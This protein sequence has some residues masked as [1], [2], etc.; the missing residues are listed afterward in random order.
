MVGW[1]YGSRIPY[2]SLLYNVYIYIYI[3][4]DTSGYDMWVQN[5][6]LFVQLYQ[7]DLN[8]LRETGL[9]YDVGGIGNIWVWY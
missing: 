2:S 7:Y 1:G 3:N 4:K 6:E 5:A 8:G 9:R